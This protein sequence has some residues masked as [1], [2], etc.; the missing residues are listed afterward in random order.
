MDDTNVIGLSLLSVFVLDTWLIH[1]Y[2]KN[3]I[4]EIVGA[5]H[6]ISII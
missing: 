6:T 2:I 5:V 4:K 1:I 3:K